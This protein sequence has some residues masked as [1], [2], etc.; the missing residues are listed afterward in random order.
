MAESAT[1]APPV[2]NTE[3]PAANATLV[4]TFEEQITSSLVLYGLSLFCIIVGGVRSSRYVRK[5][6]EKGR[7]KIEGSL[8]MK[9]ARWFPL[10]ASF[11]LFGLYCFFNPEKVSWENLEA[12]LPPQV[13]EYLQPL[14]SWQQSRFASA[15][16]TTVTPRLY[17]RVLEFIPPNVQTTLQEF[18]EHAIVPIYAYIPEITKAHCMK[19]LLFLLCFEGCVALAALLK[20]IFSFFLRLLPI[21]DRCPKRN[22]TY[23][24]SLKKSNSEMEEGDIEDAKA[25]DV[26]Y[27]F[28]MEW[29]T[30]DFIATIFCL[31][32]AVSHLYRRHWITNNILGVAFSIFGIENLHLSSFK[33]GTMLLVGLFFYDIFWVFATDVMTTVAKGI[34]AP[35]L[36][37]FPQDIYRN[38]WLDANKYSMLGLGD[39]VIPGIFIALLRRFDQRVGEL[40]FGQKKDNKK[41]NNENK[42]FRIYFY[43][44]IVAYAL[45]LFITMGVMHHFKRA[46]PALLYLV[47][48]CLFIPLLL[49]VCR[50]ELSLLWNYNEGHFVNQVEEPKK[51]SESKKKN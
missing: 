5:I 20:P 37:Q 4:F 51:V 50:G 16:T 39:V 27:W 44:T 34:D 47:P 12:H 23:F 17:E 19:F 18:H 30:H 15:S 42:K 6:V 26:T 10:T 8:T 21:G 13:S 31:S 32:V 33:A 41:G 9:E 40:Q 48:T 25:K 49:S 14:K 24:L 7:N 43:V 28:K 45:G 35:I 2:V 22:T 1:A 46:Q 36:L 3:A 29:D 11:V 38:G